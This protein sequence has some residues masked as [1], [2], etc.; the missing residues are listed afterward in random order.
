MRLL[1][2]EDDA[3]LGPSIRSALQHAGYAVDLAIDGVQAEA[4]GDIEPYDIVVLDLGLPQQSGLTVLANWR[5]KAIKC[6]WLF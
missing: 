4:F 3:V 2:V 6:P 1:L 5:K